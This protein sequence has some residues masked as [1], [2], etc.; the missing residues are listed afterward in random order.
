MED[1]MEHIR[2][3][4]NPMHSISLNKKI[5]IVAPK[6]N[7]GITAVVENF[8]SGGLN[9]YKN[10]RFHPSSYES[11]GFKKVVIF[12]GQYIKA[13]VLFFNFRPDLIHIHVSSDGSFYR[14]SFYVILAK[15]FKKR[16][17][18]HIHPTHFL[19]FIEKA[20]RLKQKYILKTLG[21]ANV[22][23]TLT[24][25]VKN[26]LRDK[27]GL[28]SFYEVLPNPINL[29]DYSCSGINGRENN[30]LLYLG[31][32]IKK[33]GIY[34]LI[35]A[36]PLIKKKMEDFQLI[37][38]GNKETSKLRRLVEENHLSD[39][40]HVHEWV[41][42]E[43]KKELLKKTTALI[44]PSYTEG[45]PNVILEAMACG[46]PILCTPVGGNVSILKGNQNCIFF[47]P[48]DV[49][50]MAEKVI[51]LLESEDLRNQMSQRNLEAVKEYDAKVL[52]DKLVIFY[53]R[54]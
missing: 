6:T 30:M 47:N 35:S 54:Y 52:A 22:I 21:Y 17:I 14:K 3:E 16:I 25:H 7:S 33:K 44:L 43:E 11:G 45:I 53:N 20:S 28:D 51:S 13:V 1:G 18:I 8:L 2:G 27:H 15:I 32:I 24:D 50:D 19:D 5:V 37:V 29:S 42:R 39:Y 41:G 49:G 4:Y 31:W 40:I 23:I 26:Q 38:C 12:L 48:G 9:K 36:A 10:I 34:D 46:V